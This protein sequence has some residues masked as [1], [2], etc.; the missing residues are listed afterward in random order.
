VFSLYLG[1]ADGPHARF[2]VCT[3]ILSFSSAKLIARPKLSA[4]SCQTGLL[5]CLVG[6]S[7]GEINVRSSLCAGRG[8]AKPASLKI[9]YEIFTGKQKP[10]RREAVGCVDM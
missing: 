1:V 8:L 7:L 6:I 9:S 4:A 10:V 2:F 5:A 3:I